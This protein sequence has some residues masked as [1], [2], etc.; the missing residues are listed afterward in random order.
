MPRLENGI[1]TAES[2]KGNSGIR[3]KNTV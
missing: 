2:K 3:F 1:W